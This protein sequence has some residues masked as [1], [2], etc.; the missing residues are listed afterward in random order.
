MSTKTIKP[1]DSSEGVTDQIGTN[2]FEQAALGDAGNARASA[3]TAGGGRRGDE[4]GAPPSNRAPSN[5]KGGKEEDLKR[6]NFRSFLLGV[7]SLYLSFPGNLTETWE[8]ELDQLKLL[9][10]S[11]SKKEQ[12]Q[13]QLKIGEHLFE[14]SDHGAKRFP[15]I[16]MDNCFLIKLTRSRARSLPLA[17]VQI[18]STY[19]AFSGVEEATADLC[20]IIAQFGG[21]AS[22]PIVSRVDV[23]LD[24]TCAVDFDGLDQNCWMTRANKLA[25]YYDRRIPCPFT[26]WVVGV[27]GDLSSRLYEKTVEIE[28]KSH[29][30][31]LHELWRSNGWLTGGKVWRQEFQLRREVLKQLRIEDVPALLTQ[32]ASLW[33]YLTQDWLRLAIPNPSDDTRTRWPT[34]PV[35]QSISEAYVLPL[36]QPRLERF[37]PQRL[38]HDEWM[39]VNGLGGLTSFMASRGIEDMG[40]GIGE[41]F[42]RAEMYHHT[43]GLELDS[44]IKGKVKTKARK[45][46]TIDNRKNTVKAAC[47]LQEAI[48]ESRH[49]KDGESWKHSI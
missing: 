36:D 7:D 44:Y 46:N 25:K 8:I 5:S 48:E 31:Y 24:F 12:A 29:K 14:V 1:S 45:Y 40:E 43:K 27:G 30:F 6:G 37:R 18:S 47:R 28:C 33:R 38:P 21:D 41:F 13:A 34:H 19:L 16:L 3:Q 2:H 39:L 23:F 10:Q 20:S 9:A 11:E 32:Q 42:H 17:H 35:W 15:F 22:S 26:G 4:T 49:V